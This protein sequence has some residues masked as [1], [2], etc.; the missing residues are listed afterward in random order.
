VASAQSAFIFNSLRRISAPKRVAFMMENPALQF[1]I[2]LHSFDTANGLR[3]QSEVS[4]LFQVDDRTASS[5]VSAVP[6]VVFDNL[7]PQIALKIRDR[8]QVLDA[9]GCKFVT[10]DEQSEEVPRINWPELPEFAQVEMDREKEKEKEKE[11][12]SK[13]KEAKVPEGRSRVDA[14]PVTSA[15]MKFSCPTCG[16]NFAICKVGEDFDAPITQAAVETAP[17]PLSSK[18]GTSSRRGSRRE[19]RSYRRLQ[20]NEV[21][22][23][24][25]PRSS[26]K[27]FAFEDPLLKAR[28]AT[29]DI[30]S[31]RYAT[32]DFQDSKKDS[33]DK[34]SGEEEAS[35]TRSTDRLDADPLKSLRREEGARESSNEIP[36]FSEDDL[37]ASPV[38]KDEED[39][40]KGNKLFESQEVEAPLKETDTVK[41]SED[42]ITESGEFSFSHDSELDHKALFDEDELDE[43]DAPLDIE[44]SNSSSKSAPSNPPSDEFNIFDT[45]EAKSPV[46]KAKPNPRN[47]LENESFSEEELDQMV[48][49]SGSAGLADPGL[50]ESNRESRKADPFKKT[51][52]DV[53]DD[54]DPFGGDDDDP[55][56]GDDDDPFGGDDDDPFGDD[57][58]DFLIDA[59][60]KS[61]E[62]RA[63]DKIVFED[64]E[65][66]SRSRASRSRDVIR[67]EVSSVLDPEKADDFELD[68]KPTRD[69]LDALGLGDSDD[70]LQLRDSDD[71]FRLDDELEDD[72]D[73]F[74]ERAS[75]HLSAPG[76]SHRDSKTLDEAAADALLEESDE[77]DFSDFESVTEISSRSG[78]HRRGTPVKGFHR[79]MPYGDALGLFGELDL[80]P[81]DAGD[82][83][84][85]GPDE[86]LNLSK[87]E[88]EALGGGENEDLKNALRGSASMAAPVTD[89]EADSQSNEDW[90]KLEFGE[91]YAMLGDEQGKRRERRS[92]R[93]KRRGLVPLNA[94]DEDF[95]LLGDPP[96][97]TKSGRQ[98]RSDPDLSG[99]S[100]ERGKMGPTKKSKQRVDPFARAQSGR[101]KKVDPFESEEALESSRSPAQENTAAKTRASAGAKRKAPA[102][103][104]PG[105]YGLV[106]SRINND[107]KRQQAAA[108]ISQI[109]G[110]LLD[111]ALRLTERT[112]IPV[113]K[114]VSKELAE[115]H[116]EQFKS[117][118][119]AGRVTK[120]RSNTG[121]MAK[122]RN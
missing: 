82:G 27:V 74:D 84:F 80:V 87:T 121:S 2:I 22:E 68:T 117:K 95:N 18:T 26:S 1:R 11:K 103:T 56:G 55:F 30:Q 20:E 90:R 17:E 46:A 77:D 93:L 39:P 115:H 83:L 71:E 53:D 28:Q 36:Q 70:N 42:P 64:S 61:R 14:P 122:R 101:P 3:V 113:L 79:G 47:P 66:M 54:D 120:R 5:I 49:E 88:L 91:T 45:E 108:L 69:D 78:E 59:P 92:G 60:T 67:D 104:E 48:A 109:Q 73:D 52:A 25:N 100:S 94:S 62:T 99:A 112:I 119:I 31:G 9:A 32:G 102:K 85:I 13:E 107:T 118:K 8:L 6:I 37:S 50:F 15:V 7:E 43:L 33:G 57:D 89:D 106:L 110:S 81:T 38:V 41:K 97:K 58:D 16:E 86:S 29:Q 65:E 44:E 35:N 23:P 10:T 40:F 76:A 72:F 96:A 12:E 24:K 4:R 105:E 116:L 98:N 114:G 51:R 21:P 63:D 19:T 34:G 111:E 75:T